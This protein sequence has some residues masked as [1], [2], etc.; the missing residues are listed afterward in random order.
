LKVVGISLKGK[1]K[2]PTVAFESREGE[3]LTLKLESP[4]SLKAFEINQEFTLKLSKG[5][6]IPLK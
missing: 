5:E 2:V 4:S 6:Q 3:K 1:A